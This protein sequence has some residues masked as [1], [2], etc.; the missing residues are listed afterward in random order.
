MQSGRE[1]VELCERPLELRLRP[2]DPFEQLP[3][4]ADSRSRKQLDEVSETADRPRP[5]PLLE[6]SALLVASLEQA[7]ARGRKLGDPRA[8]LCL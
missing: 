1:L 5:E 3:A 8:H 2:P 6:P 4:G 7:A